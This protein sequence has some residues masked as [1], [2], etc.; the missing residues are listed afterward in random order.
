M[1]QKRAIAGI[2]A[3]LSAGLFV[4][5]AA[6]APSLV[7][8]TVLQQADLSAPGREGVMAIAELQPKGTTGR[9]THPGE[10]IS[11]VL[12]GPLTVEIDGKPAKVVQTGEAFWIPAGVVHNATAAGSGTAKVLVT[13][14]VEKGKPVTSPAP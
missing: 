3:A 11:Y 12:A 8:R 1:T 9:H 2:A 7:K 4:G 10:E 5:L 6:Q 14:V 13:Y